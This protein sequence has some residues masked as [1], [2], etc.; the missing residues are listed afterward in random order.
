MLRNTEDARRT[1]VTARLVVSGLAAVAP[2]VLRDGRARLSPP[3]PS[4]NRRA[5]S[6]RRHA[7]GLHQSARCS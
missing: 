1:T 7:M 3:L 6:V 2:Q 5:W 4:S